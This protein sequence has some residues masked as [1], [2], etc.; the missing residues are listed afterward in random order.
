MEGLDQYIY[1]SPEGWQWVDEAGCLS[2]HLPTQLECYWELIGYCVV[3]LGD[4]I[5]EDV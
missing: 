3:V 2:S 4:F 1:F 5:L